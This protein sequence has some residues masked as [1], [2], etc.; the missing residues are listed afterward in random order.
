MIRPLRALRTYRRLN[1]YRQVAFVLAKYGFGD[2]ANRLGIGSLRGR[3]R[4]AAK[5]ANVPTP[6]RV[7]MALVDLGPTF[8]KFGQLLSTR[9]DILPERY[10][11]ELEKLQDEV[12]P[13]PGEEVRRIIFDELGR[14]PE[15]LFQSFEPD[16]VASGS[17]A[18]VHKAVTHSGIPVAVKVQR[19][20]I[21]RREAA[22]GHGQCGYQQGNSLYRSSHRNLQAQTVL[23][24]KEQ[25]AVRIPNQL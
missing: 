20:A 13:F 5:A 14:T 19:P 2:V 7:R 1:R 22:T 10:I 8:V 11:L 3:L 16:A 4:G 15:A 12:T 21:R 23:L 24:R 18:Q 25:R 17:I 6:Q 9:P